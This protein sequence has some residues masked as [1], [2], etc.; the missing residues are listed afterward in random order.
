MAGKYIPKGLLPKEFRGDEENS[1]IEVELEFGQMIADA[2]AKREVKNMIAKARKKV[3]A[4]AKTDPKATAKK[5]KDKK[6]IAKAPK[7]KT[8][9]Q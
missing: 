2:R 4:A 1:I 3:L 8:D 7:A 5:A 6:I 9:Q